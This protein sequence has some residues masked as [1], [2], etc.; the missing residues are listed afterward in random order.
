[1]ISLVFSGNQLVSVEW[2]NKKKNQFFWIK[3]V[4]WYHLT[5]YLEHC[6]KWCQ[7]KMN[8]FG[9]KRNFLTV[10]LYFFPCLKGLLCNSKVQ[11]ECICGGLI[12]DQYQWLTDYFVKRSN[13]LTY[14]AF[15]PT[16]TLFASDE[17]RSMWNIGVR[18]HF[19]LSDRAVLIYT[20]CYFMW[21]FVV[22]AADLV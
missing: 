4:S 6:Q 12:A 20:S 5:F 13:L 22:S 21:V 19:V 8:S 2:N 16:V 15:Q 7:N 11:N 14:F 1:M 10:L 3:W 9:N 17:R 18:I